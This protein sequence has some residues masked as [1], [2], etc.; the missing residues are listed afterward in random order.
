MHLL[1]IHVEKNWNCIRHIA[2]E[3]LSSHH[4]LVSRTS[5]R[6]DLQPFGDERKVHL[7]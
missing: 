6:F 5:V 7:K 4:Q 1:P 3:D 2:I